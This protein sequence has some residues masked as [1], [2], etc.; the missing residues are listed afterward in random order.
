LR[1]EG[2]NGGVP[3][4]GSEPGA[5]KSPPAEAPTAD[6]TLRTTGSAALARR[7]AGPG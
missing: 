6:P 7:V 4:N 3:V 5:A 2:A 1:P